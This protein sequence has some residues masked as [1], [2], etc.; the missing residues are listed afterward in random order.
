MR[1]DKDDR[2]MILHLVIEKQ[3]PIEMEGQ[4]ENGKMQRG[5]FSQHFKLV[6]YT[7]PGES[8]DLITCS[9]IVM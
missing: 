3:E 6:L 1:P 7:S 2:T 9:I 5:A 8:I 4:C